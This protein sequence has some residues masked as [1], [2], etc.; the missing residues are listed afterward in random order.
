MIAKGV[1]PWLVL[2]FILGAIILPFGYW[3][4][5]LALIVAGA[6]AL[7][8]FRDPHRSPGEGITAA[9]DGTVVSVNEESDTVRISTYL[10]L[11]NVHVTRSP[12]EGRITNIHH[13]NGK[14]LPAFL[15][16]VPDQNESFKIDLD[17]S[18]GEVSIHLFAGALARRIVPYV[19]VGD[20][21]EKGSRLGLIR[22]GSRVEILLPR[23]EVE[24]CVQPKMQVKAGQTTIARLTE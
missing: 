21:L 4:F 2:P 18:I 5:T 10:A 14:H 7:L 8:F 17:S 12:I 15:S 9:A 1:P 6:A 19:K 23:G 20:S 11:R 3:Y 13:R 16:K 22:F 24:V